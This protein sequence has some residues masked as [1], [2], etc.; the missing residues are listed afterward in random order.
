MSIKPT[1]FS[2]DLETISPWLRSL[3]CSLTA[4]LSGY[5]V[6]NGTLWC[7][8]I[9]RGNMNTPAMYVL[10]LAIMMPM[11]LAM[12]ASQ[13]RY[14]IVTAVFSLLLCVPTL[15]FNSPAS[16]AKHYPES[17]I[18]V[19]MPG[20]TLLVNAVFLKIVRRVASLSEAT[21]AAIKPI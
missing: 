17:I 15:L 20:L 18:L 19:T 5:V 14:W 13:R 7:M 8:N 3:L 12:V 2:S 10:A 9:M 21:T 11:N 4:V 1:N 16:L 6:V